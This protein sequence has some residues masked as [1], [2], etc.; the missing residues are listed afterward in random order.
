MS[1]FQSPNQRAAG[2]LA[3]VS[4]MVLARSSEGFFLAHRADCWVGSTYKRSGSVPDA[5]R[6]GRSWSWRGADTFWVRSIQGASEQPTSKPI[7]AM[8]LTPHTPAFITL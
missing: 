1:L 7:P 2:L 3:I 4:S 8:R 5:V 6:G